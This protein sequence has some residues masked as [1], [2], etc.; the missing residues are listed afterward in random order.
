MNI[1]IVQDSIRS[2]HLVYVTEFTVHTSRGALPARIVNALNIKIR[3]ML[4]GRFVVGYHQEDGVDEWET[5]RTF[6]SLEAAVHPVIEE[7]F[8]SQPLGIETSPSGRP[9]IET[10]KKSKRKK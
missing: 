3:Q 10:I 1:S 5:N 6:A 4:N 7:R 9:S 8:F 2:W